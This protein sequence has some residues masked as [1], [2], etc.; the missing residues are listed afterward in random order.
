VSIDRPGPHPEGSPSD[1]PL[2]ADCR[3][4]PACRESSQLA[5]SAIRPGSVAWLETPTCWANTSR[6]PP[7]EGSGLSGHIWYEKVAKTPYAR[8][9]EH[10]AIDESIKERLRAEHATLNPMV[11]KREIERRL[12]AVY[13]T[14]KRYGKTNYEPPLGNSLL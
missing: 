9:L 13:D 6:S 12:K 2:A 7:F 5:A 3:T 10:S 1:A 11:L 14:Q 4:A 8:I